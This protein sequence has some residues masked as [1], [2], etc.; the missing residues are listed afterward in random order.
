MAQHVLDP[1][2]FRL[3]FPAFSSEV[4]YPNGVL[5]VFWGSAVAYLGDYDG[6][7]LTGAGL[8]SALNYMSAHLLALTDMINRGQTPGMVTQ[9]TID[10]VSVTVAAPP[11]KSA[12]A[13]W[14]SLTPYG[15]QLWA[16][17]SVTGAGGVYIGGGFP[18]AGFR[19]TGGN[20]L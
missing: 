20:F 15:V 5:D 18:R 2:T 10:K 19:Q 7:L 3:L 6:L 9:A 14:L 13:H 16:L 11:A 1:V 12:W 17:L 8:Q 4:V